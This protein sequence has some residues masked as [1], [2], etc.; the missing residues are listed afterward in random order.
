MPPVDR[1]RRTCTLLC[2]A[3]ETCFSLA[4]TAPRSPDPFLPPYANHWHRSAIRDSDSTFNVASF[5]CPMRL[6]VDLVSF[7]IANLTQLTAPPATTSQRFLFEKYTATISL[8]RSLHSHCCPCDL[9][10]VSV[11]SSVSR[12]LRFCC[13][14]PNTLDTIQSR[15]HDLTLPLRALF[16]PSISFLPSDERRMQLTASVAQTRRFRT[17]RW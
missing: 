2:G 1:L 13:V 5:R 9:C 8:P 14:A 3:P 16:R 11:C 12:R 7:S 6:P 10:N 15:R 4:F 17:L